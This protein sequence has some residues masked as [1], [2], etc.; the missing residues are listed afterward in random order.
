MH[1]PPKLTPWGRPDCATEI[2]P[3]VWRLSTPSHGGY[4]LAPEQQQR[5]EQAF[6]LF[7]P[8]AG[9]PWYEEDCDWAIVALALVDGW[10][11]YGLRNAIRMVLA[12]TSWRVERGWHDVLAW[13]EQDPRGK[14]I[15]ERAASWEREYAQHWER[16]SLYGGRD[17][18]GWEVCLRRVGDGERRAVRMPNYPEKMIYTPA[19]INAMEAIAW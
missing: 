8:F 11:A 15:T 1:H 7:R 14:A 12:A 17:S 19:E 9:K 4:W 18:A 10:D 2:V 13:L 5:V 6:P 16:G 3:G